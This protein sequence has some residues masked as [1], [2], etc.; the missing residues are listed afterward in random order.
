[1]KLKRIGLLLLLLLCLVL[2]RKRQKT[3]EEAS[4]EEQTYRRKVLPVE[5]IWQRIDGVTHPN[6]ACGPTTA[7]MLIHYMSR[8]NDL[9][10]ADCVEVSPATLVNILYKKLATRPWGTSARSWQKGMAAYLNE[11]WPEENWQV[12][13]QGAKGQFASYCQSIDRGMPV[14]LRFIFNYS[15]AAFASH[16][17][18]LGIGYEVDE[19]GGKIAVLDAD[20]GKSNNRVYW[21][22]WNEHERFFKT[23]SILREK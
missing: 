16:H 21:I 3:S 1:M 7:A 11:R 13:V 23:L 8:R 10:L 14:V 2:S 18:I 20:G 17:Y 9:A 15:S 19:A 6:S 22:R 4:Y 5:R 12:A